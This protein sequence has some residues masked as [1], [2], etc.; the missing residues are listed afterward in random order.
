MHAGVGYASKVCLI[1]RGWSLSTR[2][3]P[4]PTWCGCE[5]AARVACAWSATRRMDIGRRSR[6]SPV[7]EAIESA[8]AALRYLPQYSPDLNPI[9]NCFSKIKA[10][11]HKAAERTINRLCRRIG[12]IAS[13]VSAQE[14]SN[15]LAHAGYGST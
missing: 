8:G 5:A 6:S 11:L 10:H 1:L 14:Y 4:A 2:P 12:K 3:P 9:E 13:S 7:R 15:Y